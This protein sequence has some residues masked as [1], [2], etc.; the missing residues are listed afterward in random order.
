MRLAQH[1]ISFRNE[2]NK[3]N[4]ISSSQAKGDNNIKSMNVRFY[5]SDDI[6]ITFK[7]HFCCK[8]VTILSLCKQRCYGR[9]KV[10]E[11]L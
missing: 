7:S 5:L 3:F 11:N 6:K 8:N 1:F 9:H 4:K 10:L 2:F